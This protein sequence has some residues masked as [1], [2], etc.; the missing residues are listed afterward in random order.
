MKYEDSINLY[1]E[2]IY[3]LENVKKSVDKITLPSTEKEISFTAE[4]KD[5]LRES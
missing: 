4:R 1:E 2:K 3:N 5:P